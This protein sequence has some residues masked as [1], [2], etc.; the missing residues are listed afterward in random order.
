MLGVPGLAQHRAL[1][2]FEN[3][4]SYPRLTVACSNRDQN[5]ADFGEG[6]E[7]KDTSL[8]GT[9]GLGQGHRERELAQALEHPGMGRLVFCPHSGISREANSKH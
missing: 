9:A 7:G 1:V 6:K 8:L 4:V 5:E 2:C 3:L